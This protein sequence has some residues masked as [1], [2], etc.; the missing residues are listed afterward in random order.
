MSKD[1]H[2]AGSKKELGGLIDEL[3]LSELRKRFLR[4]R[5]LD[6]MLWLEDKAKQ[7]QRRY[8][9]LRLTTIIAGVVVPA[10]VGLN[11]RRE[12]VT[13][14]LAWVTFA[15]SLAVALAAALDGF[16]RFGDRWRNYRRTAEA[17]KSQGWQFLQL[18][19]P[20][21]GFQSHS[22]A[23]PVFAGQIEALIQQDVEAFITQVVRE[24]KTDEAE[25][26]KPA[27]EAETGSS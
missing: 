3:E 23:Y 8:Y 16:F 5:W 20:Y 6:Q 24:R 18:A 10:L 26:E 12:S 25:S 27:G 11:V 7:N 14:A 22:K 21:A 1:D 13:S 4:S 19:G 2:G 9:S 17:L 15:L